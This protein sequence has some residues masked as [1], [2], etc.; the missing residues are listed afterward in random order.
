LGININADILKVKENLKQIGICFLF[1]P[2]MHVAMKHVMPVRKAL[3]IRTVFNMLG[4]LTNPARASKQVIG[5]FD[6]KLCEIYGKVLLGMGHKKAYIIHG[7]DGM[8][9]ATISDATKVVYLNNGAL[10]TFSISPEDFGIKRASVEEIKGGDTPL[11]NANILRD[12]LSCKTKG[13]KKDISCLNAAF[14]INLSGQGDTLLESYKIACE[15]V[16][17][18]KAYDKL[19]EWAMS[20]TLD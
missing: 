14:A 12:I 2:E 13:A 7:N 17:S 18:G 11:E 6:E 8:D 3:G 4:P 19:N 16:D 1:A 5:V 9:E 10:E 15:T 20:F